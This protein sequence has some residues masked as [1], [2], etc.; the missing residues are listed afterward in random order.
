MRITISL[1]A[2]LFPW[3][4]YDQNLF[5]RRRL[6]SSSSFAIYDSEGEREGEQ[7][8]VKQ[9]LKR[10]DVIPPWLRGGRPRLR[11]KVNHFSGKSRDV[12]DSNQRMIRR[13]FNN[14]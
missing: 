1:A 8:E 2:I 4:A 14:L 11:M 12:R 6:E 3:F 10:L 7:K 13:K 5:R 9:Q